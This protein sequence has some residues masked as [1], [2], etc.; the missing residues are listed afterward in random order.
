MYDF[1]KKRIIIWVTASYKANILIYLKK[2]WSQWTSRMQQ[3]QGVGNYPLMIVK[4]I[5]QNLLKG[6]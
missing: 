6:M 4:V 1:P 2:Y 5:I 3:S